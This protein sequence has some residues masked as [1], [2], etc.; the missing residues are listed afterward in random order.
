MDT[1]KN[2]ALLP[3]T[4]QKMTK[5]FLNFTKIFKKSFYIFNIY[6]IL[7]LAAFQI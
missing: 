5:Y 1:G 6:A 4:R 2:A 3:D 7:F